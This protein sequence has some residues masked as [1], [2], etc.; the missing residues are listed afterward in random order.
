MSNLG[1]LKELAKRLQLF[2]L[3]RGDID[4]SK[5]SKENL[6]FL[7]KIMKQE[8][9]MRDQSRYVRL[10]HD[11]HLP[12][13]EFLPGK[14]NS[15]IQWQI[16]HLEKL[17]WIDEEQNLFIIGKCS[18]GK[19]SLACHL[20]KKAIAA[21]IK[22]SYNTIESFLYTLGTKDYIHNQMQ[23]YKYWL[24]CSMIIIDDMMYAKIT[25][26]ELM[27]FYHAIML[28]NETRSIVII[29]NREL[30]AWGQGGNDSHLMQTLIERLSSN[31]QQIRLT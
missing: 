10:E 8:Q 17:G 9:D 1:E 28:L 4:L 7:Q 22:V 3:A 16:E 24:S 20:G 11:S 21:D 23:R 14:L 19:T 15:G 25:D 31:S 5:A 12:R 27:N 6:D 29:T 30:S 13:K 26:E 18:T 2:H